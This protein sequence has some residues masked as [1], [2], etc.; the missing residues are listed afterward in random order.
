MKQTIITLLFLCSLSAQMTAQQK[1]TVTDTTYTDNSAGVFFSVRDI[2]YS[3]G[4]ESHTKTR[5]GD[6]LALFDAFYSR[7]VQQATQMATDAKYVI[8]FPSLI[9]DMNRDNNLLLATTGKDALDTITARLSAPLLEDGWTLRSNGTAEDI[10]FIVNANGQLRYTITGFATRNAT[11]FGSVIRM[12]NY[13]DGNAIDLYRVASGNYKTIDNRLTLRRPGGP[14]NR[15][16]LAPP[17]EPVPDP[18]L[19]EPK[20]GTP[21]TP[22]KAGGTG[23]DT[24]KPK[25]K[26]RQ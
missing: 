16:A 14:A 26:R 18:V 7:F 23:T 3:N 9:G 25:K 1:Y 15:S 21:V 5:I 11:L 6:T 17:P 24:K 2:V 20:N 13:K 22:A 19:A 4:E 10:L 12:N 8:T